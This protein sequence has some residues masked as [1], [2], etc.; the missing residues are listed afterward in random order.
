VSVRSVSYG[1]GVQSTALLVLA[2]EGRIDFR[3]FLMANVGDDS[4]H[5]DT[6]RYVRKVAKPYAFKHGIELVELSKVM[7]RGD[8][9]GQVETLLGRLNRGS[10]A[11][12]VRRSAGGPPMS[13]SC[14][15]DFKVGVVGRALKRMGAT[16]DDPATVA[17]GISVDEMERAK[18]GIDPLAPYQ[19]RVYPLLD[20]GLRRSD[21]R[22]IIEAAG[23]PV[24]PK[25]ACWFCPFHDDD[26]W[27]NLHSDRPDLFEQAVALEGRMSA[28]TSDGR[29]V[30]LTRHG[31]PLDRAVATDQLRLDGVDGCES[32]WCHT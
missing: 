4:E 32:G 26:A 16:V 19:R 6:I 15:A 8:R 7:V 18:P 11:I 22:T 27:K 17:L 25:S 21:C 10:M 3:V 23:L 5:P 20:L 1:G 29:P 28:A 30:F 31:V 13:R 9:A 14:T 12:P 24:P 2:A